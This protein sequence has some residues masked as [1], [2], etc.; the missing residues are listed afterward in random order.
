M[1]PF[2]QKPIVMDDCLMDWAAMYPLPYDKR[3]VDPY[4]RT[5]VILMSGTEFENVWYTHQLSRHQPDQEVRRQ[6]ALIRRVE[7]Q[8]QKAVAM[9]KPPDETVLEHTIGYEQLAVDLTAALAKREREEIV[10]DALNFALLEDFDH[11]YRYAQ[12]LDMDQGVKAEDLVGRYTEVMPARPTIAH[13]RYP[14]DSIK[15]HIDNKQSNLETKLCVGIITAAEQQTM[16]FYMN[17][18]NS[19]KTDRG[20]KLYEEIGMVEEQHV[21]EYGSL[22]DV[23]ASWLEGLLMHQYT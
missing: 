1:N 17:V 12:L 11:L 2:D 13:H 3:T 10:R 21:T 4:T 22:M 20:R 23:N 7:Q 14:F 6:V 8:Q 19:Y 16:N 15:P 18:C 5:R 9:L